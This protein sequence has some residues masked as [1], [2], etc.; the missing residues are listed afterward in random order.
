MALSK[1]KYCT[2]LQCPKALWLSEYKKGLERSDHAS[3]GRMSAG[4]KLGAL[5]LELFGKYA[6]ARLF[7]PNGQ[8]D[9]E[10][11]AALT[12]TLMENGEDVI[13]E[14]SFAH[15]G[16]FC[17]VDILHREGG[18]YAL[19]EV[20]SSSHAHEIFI[21]DL[22]YQ[23]YVLR[24]CGVKITGIYLVYI[25]GRYVFDGELKVRELFRV[26]EVSDRV[27]RHYGRVRANVNDALRVL[28]EKSE[29]LCDISEGCNKPHLC[30]FWEYCTRDLPS[31]SVFDLYKLGFDKKIE[32]YRQG[33]IAVGAFAAEAST[34]SIRGL[35][36]LHTLNDLPT[37]VDKKGIRDFLSTL[38]YPLYF[39][40]FETMQL[41]VPEY[42][43]TSPNE[44]VPFQYS[45]HYIEREGGEIYHKEFLA[46]SGS[47]P[48]YPLAKRLCED[49]PKNVCVLA[50]NKSFECA[51][52]RTLAKTY[53]ELA[54]HLLNIADNVRDLIVPFQKGY[55]YNRAMGASLSIKSVLPAIY[56][57]DP[58]LDYKNLS[59]VHN[60]SEAMEIFPLI[61]DMEQ[62][63]AERA[64]RALLEYCR[65]DT[66]AM[67]KVYQ[68]LADGV[69]K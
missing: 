55:Y 35:Q 22:A 40:D 62:E 30:P 36:I 18:G 7:L 9:T 2:F 66:Y 52:I 8:P 51:R 46:M 25:N 34:S 17:S 3:Y 69:G 60:G 43:G 48:R 56:P 65:L 33:R 68:A 44:Q 64:R 27:R 23:A 26:E 58:T 11:M 50:Y 6:D 24:S 59:D 61:K 37:H 12:K 14:A 63:D 15:N 4:E 5:A 39:L 16:C 45:L 42:V 49:I 53:P 47:D 32:C 13:C 38:S 41:P 57:N 29:P 54:E 19:Y 10:G 1:T 67:V 28:N 20:K 21:S 31:P